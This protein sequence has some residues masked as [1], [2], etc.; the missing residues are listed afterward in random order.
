M[1]ILNI[2]APDFMAEEEIT[3]FSDSVSRWIDEK[4][5]DGLIVNGAVRVVGLV[6]S[7]SRRAQTGLLYHYAFVMIIGLVLLLAVLIRYWR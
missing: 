5:I 7:V 6:A 4:V 2:P 3:L 1:N